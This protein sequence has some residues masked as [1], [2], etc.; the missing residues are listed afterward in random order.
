MS[1]IG[2]STSSRRRTT[3]R[4]SGLSFATTSA[5]ATINEEDVVSVA[6]RIFYAVG[7]TPWEKWAEPPVSDQVAALFAREE[8]GRER[9]FGRVLDLGCGSGIWAVTLAERGWEVTGVDYVAKA[10]RNADDR[11]R[12][13]GVEVRTVQGDVTKLRDTE[14]GDG[15]RFLV[16]FG[17][18]HD[19]LSDEQR[20]AM[21]REVTTIAA[22]GATLLLLA[23]IPARRG[24]L[25]RGASRDDI[26]AAFPEWTITHEERMDQSRLPRYMKNGAP[27]FYSLQRN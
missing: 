19:E 11:A 3:I 1:R 18:F 13:A 9:P 24:P 5:G 23:W 12:R 6:Y 14:V 7:F 17:L 15:F 16:D 8:Q 22:P 10:L 27:R 21:G 25:P 26:E 4:R 2:W 20:L